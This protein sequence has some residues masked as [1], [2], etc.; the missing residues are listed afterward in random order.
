MTKSIR[1]NL[2][3]AQ[4]I[5]VKLGTNVVMGADGLP[6]RERL[7]SI[8]EQVAELRGSGIDVL[9]VSSG[10]VGVGSRMLGR[11]EVPSSTIDRQACAALGQGAIVSLYCD[12]LQTH[13]CQGAQVLLTEADFA[14]RAAYLNLHHT[15]E[16]L[17]ELGVI[18]IINENDTV[19]VSELTQGKGEVFGDNDRLSALVASRLQADLLVLLTDV[20]GV[21]T[22]PPGEA[23]SEVISVLDEDRIVSVGEGSGLGR[24]GMLSKIR[25]ARIAASGGV[26]AVIANGMQ[27]DTLRCLHRG[28]E[29]GTLIAPRPCLNSRKHWLAFSTASSGSIVVNDGAK[30]ALAG[31][32]ASLLPAGVIATAGSFIEG[33]IVQVVDEDGVAFARGIARYS[34]EKIADIMGSHSSA[35]TA[36]GRDRFIIASEDLVI[37]EEATQ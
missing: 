33:N 2:A 28:E 24:G 29:V 35:L 32:R 26:T 20:D 23:G 18:P 1:D 30:N 7:A 4:R 16:R 3:N 15:L 14:H 21:L 11:D 9:L 8:V 22:A 10:S 36:T 25:A 34:S 12:L 19:S 5:V 27:P 37:L 31:N 6:D 13:D 17:L